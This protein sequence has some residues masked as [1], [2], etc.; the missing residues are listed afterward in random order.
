[1]SIARPTAIVDDVRR[2]GPHTGSPYTDGYSDAQLRD[3]AKLIRGWAKRRKDVFFYFNNDAM[4]W[5]PKNALTLRKLI[6]A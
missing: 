5:A 3:D 2:H 1:M 6:H 4:G